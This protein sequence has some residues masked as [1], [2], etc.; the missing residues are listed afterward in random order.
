M[1][2][3]VVDSQCFSY[4]VDA[5][6][7]ETEP[8]G[9]F[10]DQQKALFRCYLY[11]PD[12][13]YAT[14]K[15]LEECRNIS[16]AERRKT[17]ES[18]FLTLFDTINIED[19]SVVASLSNELLKYHAKSADCRILAEAISGCADHFLSYDQKLIRRLGPLCGGMAVVTPA[20]FWL[21]QQ[22]PKNARPYKRPYESGSSQDRL[23]ETNPLASQHWWRW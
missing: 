16:D 7:G 22:I 1:M 11:L 18:F 20:D 9:P 6:T 4:L 2:R 8:T 3:I 19:Q 17:H 12:T 15:I 14:Q 23:S 5:W 10:A 21:G 13:F